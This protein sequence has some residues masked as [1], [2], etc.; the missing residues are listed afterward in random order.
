MKVSIIDLSRNNEIKILNTRITSSVTIISGY[1]LTCSQEEDPIR[2]TRNKL[3]AEGL[4]EQPAYIIPSGELIEKHIFHLPKMPDKEIDK[5]LPRQIAQA[6]DT[7]ETMI[8]S[9]MKNGSVEDRQV[10]KTEISAFFCPKSKMLDFLEHLKSEGIQ[11]QKIIPEAQGLKTLVEMSSGGLSERSGVV[12]IDLMSNR[13][14]LNIFRNIYWGLEREFM[15][16]ME[17][18]D[19]L[20]DEDFSRISTELNRTFQYFKQRN[21]SYTVDHALIYGSSGNIDHL[22]NLIS[23]NLAVQS[24]A[25]EPGFLKGKISMPSHLKDSREFASIFALPISTALSTLNKKCLDIFPMEF[26]EKAKLPFRLLGLAISAAVIAGIL[27]GSTFY[28][29]N[30]KSS[31]KQDITK[32]KQ[33]YQSLSKNVAI[34]DATKKSRASYFKQRYYIDSPLQYSYSVGDF[35]RKLS[36]IV[37]DGIE[38]DELVI[39]PSGQNFTFLLSGRIKALDNI[40]A[41]SHFLEFY[42][43]LKE[44]DGIIR[45]DSSNVDINADKTNP[46]PQAASTPEASTEKKSTELFFSIDGEVEIQ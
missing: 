45:V 17:A 22:K 13:I 14:S 46:V 43:A 9:Y 21:R 27:L 33:T 42:G 8:F 1:Y 28:F 30:I 6:K 3:E 12:V 34:I 15:F 20:T 36:F 10:E 41:Q 11:P 4:L 29:E 44:F 16:R 24:T 19:D 18:G 35:I 5:V 7:T 2:V 26:K 37:S 23:D 38:L 25:I 39:E 40:A 32:I 31:Y